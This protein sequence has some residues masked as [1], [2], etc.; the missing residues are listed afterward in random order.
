VHT[1]TRFVEDTL[2]LLRSAGAVA[3][4]DSDGRVTAVV[5]GRNW[6]ELAAGERRSLV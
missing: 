1:E 3:A 2:L 6:F 4:L 5:E